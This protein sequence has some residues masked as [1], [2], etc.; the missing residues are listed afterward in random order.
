MLPKTQNIPLH[1]ASKCTHHRS[2][3]KLMMQNTHK[4]E[5]NELY[6]FVRSH[7]PDMLTERLRQRAKPFIKLERISSGSNQLNRK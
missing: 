5:R 7:Y 3:N 1:H 6:T 2:Y 4:R